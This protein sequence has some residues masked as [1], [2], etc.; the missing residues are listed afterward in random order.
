MRRIKKNNE[1]DPAKLKKGQVLVVKVPPFYDREYLYE[2]T[3]AGEKVIRADLYHSPTVKK[4]W[5]ISDLSL[6][7]ANGMI[8]FATDSDLDRLAKGADSGA[9]GSS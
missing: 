5:S 8:R 6:L 2:I 3:G 4:H 9:Q 1:F 7:F